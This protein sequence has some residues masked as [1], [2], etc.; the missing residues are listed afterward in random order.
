MARTLKIALIVFLF[1]FAAETCYAARGFRIGTG[2][3]PSFPVFNG[4]VMD[5][6]N[7][8]TG[9]TWELIEFGYGFTEAFSINNKLIGAGGGTSASGVNWAM[10]EFGLDARYAFRTDKPLNPYLLAG[11]GSSSLSIYDSSASIDFEPAFALDFGGGLDYFFSK[12][13]RWSVGTQLYF[14]L[15]QYHG[16]TFNDG[17]AINLNTDTTGGIFLWTVNLAYT[18]R[19]KKTFTT[20]QP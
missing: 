12:N 9:F 7:P 8:M 11:F 16:A 4:D 18:F 20:I 3:G 1:I 19:P 10:G 13:R 6:Y 2:M 15:V 5:L 14:H 17:F